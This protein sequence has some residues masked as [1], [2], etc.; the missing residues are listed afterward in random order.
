VDYS[1][2]QLL[3]NAAISAS[4]VAAY[5]PNTGARGRSLPNTRENDFDRR[6]S[7]L[8]QKGSF[9]IGGQSEG[10]SRID[11]KHVEDA[12]VVLAR[13]HTGLATF[14]VNET[15][16]G[17]EA[18]RTSRAWWPFQS[19]PSLIALSTC[20]RVLPARRKCQQ[21]ENDKAACLHDGSP[22][23]GQVE[24]MQEHDRCHDIGNSSLPRL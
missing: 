22:K 13:D 1:R 10:A 19:R 2:R 16:G 17:A 6:I 12:L 18:R 3:A 8:W 14:S 11:T 21:Q 7:L 20:Y 15:N 24:E 23:E 9:V 4:C 5:E